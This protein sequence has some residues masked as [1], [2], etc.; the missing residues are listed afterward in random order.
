VHRAGTRSNVLLPEEIAAILAV[1]LV[2]AVAVALTLF[3][4]EK[5]LAS[6]DQAPASGEQPAARP[7]TSPTPAPLPS[8]TPPPSP[9]AAPT[10]VV[11]A[12]CPDPAATGV[13]KQGATAYC[14]RLQYTDR[15]LWSLRQGDIAHP[16]LTAPPALSPGP[17]PGD[18]ESPVR[19]CMEQTGQGR[20]RCAAEI[21]RANRSMP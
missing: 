5:T 8:T 17:T 13:T 9:T 4:D 18:A 16:I 21:L 15:Y 7:T 11:D 1:L 2:A 20:L 10:V 6:E 12:R 14:S 19:I 3:S